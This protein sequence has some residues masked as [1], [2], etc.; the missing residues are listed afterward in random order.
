MEAHLSAPPRLVAIVDRAAL[1]SATAFLDRLAELLD[2]TGGDARLAVRARG[3]R[4]A[5]RLVVDHLPAHPH[6]FVDAAAPHPDRRGLHWTASAIPSRPVAH[7][8]GGWTSASVHDLPESRRAHDAGA[9]LLIYAPVYP[10]RSKPGR[11]RGL[12][13][14]HGIAGAVDRPVLALGG[15]TPER[16]IACVHAGAWGAA[17][18]SPVSSTE[19]DAVAAVR[20]LLDALPSSP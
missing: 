6:L 16:L 7:P 8:H 10:P 19:R 9:H 17:V 14:L 1:G 12:A 11:G 15:I 4:A 5:Q 18:L 20:A 2:L 13:A 3:D